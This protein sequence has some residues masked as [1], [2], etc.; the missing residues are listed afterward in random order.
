MPPRTWEL[1]PLEVLLLP[2]Y[3]LWLLL[4]CKGRWLLLLRATLLRLLLRCGP[5]RG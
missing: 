2:D 5:S 1:H 4:P 3:L